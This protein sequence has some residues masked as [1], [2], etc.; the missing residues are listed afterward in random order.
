MPKE[1]PKSPQIL[2]RK[3]PPEI[4]EK[5]GKKK[6]EMLRK[7]KYRGKVSNEDAIY[8]LIRECNQV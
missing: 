6:N 5:I 4:F 2:C 8:K 7:N 3:V 1:K